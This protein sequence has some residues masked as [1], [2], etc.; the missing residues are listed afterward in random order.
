MTYSE[1]EMTA[2]AT[3][4]NE[5]SPSGTWSGKSYLK[6]YS[7]VGPDEPEAMSEDSSMKQKELRFQ[8]DSKKDSKGTCTP[9]QFD[10]LA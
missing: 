7:N 3:H 1:T 6:N 8:K 9:F 5:A 2:M 10:V 4:S